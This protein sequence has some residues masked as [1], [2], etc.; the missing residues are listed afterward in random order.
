M[1]GTRIKQL[2]ATNG[3]DWYVVTHNRETKEGSLFHR[4]ACWA[5][6]SEPTGDRVVA[7]IGDIDG[8]AA[9]DF[10]RFDHP[11]VIGIAEP[12]EDK[13]TWDDIANQ[14]L[15]HEREAETIKEHNEVAPRLA[16]LLSSTD[17]TA[18]RAMLA[19]DKTLIPSDTNLIELAELGLITL[20]KPND[21]LRLTWVI[22]A[23]GRVVCAELDKRKR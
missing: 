21:D 2:L 12:D 10:Y 15:Q 14:L 4:V 18:L 13:G 1:A 6:V 19:G 20:W 22:T 3:G 23:L 17:V 5:V 11:D 8:Q 7:M 9:L 16:E